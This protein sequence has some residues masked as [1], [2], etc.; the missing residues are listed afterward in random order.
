MVWLLFLISWDCTNL[1][2]AVALHF[3]W[4]LGRLYINYTCYML[5]TWTKIFTF[6][7]ATENT[8][9]EYVSIFPTSA[10]IRK[11]ITDPQGL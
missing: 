8:D 5:K 6:L 4:K 11:K 3:E 10:V 2:E 7:L 1:S 9:L